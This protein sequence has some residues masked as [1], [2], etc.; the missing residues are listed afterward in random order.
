[1][2]EP[3]AIAAFSALSQ[4]HRLR[5]LRLLIAAGPQGLPAGDL[6][7]SLG[8]GASKMSFHLAHLQQAGLVTS[9]RDGRHIVYAA[10]L[11]TLTALISFLTQDCCGGRPEI[12]GP[13][14]TLAKPEC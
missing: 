8:A 1:M 2:I 5:I 6:G 9:R 7:A 10:R 12:C 11:E 4:E 3:Q 14:F 13:A